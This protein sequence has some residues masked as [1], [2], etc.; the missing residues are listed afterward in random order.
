MQL[1][2]LFKIEMTQN[3]HEFVRKCRNFSTEWPVSLKMLES[4]NWENLCFDSKS[5]S[6]QSTFFTD[7]SASNPVKPEIIATFFA[8]YDERDFTD[9]LEMV[10]H[11]LLLDEKNFTE[12]WFNQ[13]AVNIELSSRHLV[14]ITAVL[15]FP[16]IG[17]VKTDIHIA[18]IVFNNDNLS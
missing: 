17:D 4:R 7:S 1:K 10:C 6:I 15:T 11:K 13:L 16:P 12:Q 2:F 5:R 3:N 9:W 18:F 8:L 14:T